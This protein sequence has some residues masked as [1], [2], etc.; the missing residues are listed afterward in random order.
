VKVIS[1]SVKDVQAE[2]SKNIQSWQKKARER[3]EQ[4]ITALKKAECSK[5]QKIILNLLNNDATVLTAKL[6][7]ST[8]VA[9]NATST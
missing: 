1:V 9:N 5:D 7:E 2:I 6:S 4:L 8:I 3:V